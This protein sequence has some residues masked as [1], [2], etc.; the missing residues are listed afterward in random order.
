MNT[1]DLVGIC[2]SAAIGCYLVG[3]TI[4]VLSTGRKRNRKQENP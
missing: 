3:T 2:L 4:Y 1:V